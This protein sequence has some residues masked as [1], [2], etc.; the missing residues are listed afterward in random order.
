M[1]MRMFGRSSVKDVAEEKCLGEKN[2]RKD[3]LIESCQE[4]NLTTLK[5][6][7]KH[8]PRR[9]HLRRLNVT[10]IQ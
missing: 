4:Y 5:A 7:F 6:W 8:Q 9:R 1:C 3:G 2:S 10:S